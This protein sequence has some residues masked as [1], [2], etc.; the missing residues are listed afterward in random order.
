MSTKQG[1]LKDYSGNKIAPNTCSAAVLDEARSQGLSASL[2]ALVEKNALGYPTFSTTN[3]YAV[4]D[5]VF[6]DRK[7]WKFTSAHAAGAWAAA[8]VTEFSVKEYMD[9]LAARILNVEQNYLEKGTYDASTAVGLADN[10]RGDVYADEQFAVRMTGGEANEIGGIGVVQVLKG[11]G[12]AIVQI[13][14][15]PD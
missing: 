12:A 14:W 3:A 9:A 15:Y 4:D 8:D 1:N 11:A 5:K 6:Y 7:L 13:L 2:L 10:I